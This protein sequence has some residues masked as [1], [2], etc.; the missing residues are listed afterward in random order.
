I[1]VYINNI[2]IANKNIEEHFKYIKTVLDI[3]DKVY[4]YISIEKSFIAYP[5]VRLLSYIVNGE[6]V[7]KTDDRI[8]I[9]KKF[10]FPDT[11]ETLE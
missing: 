2:I 6:G 3:F 8:A 11:F 10:K 5:L 4:I 7:A 1:Y 9:F